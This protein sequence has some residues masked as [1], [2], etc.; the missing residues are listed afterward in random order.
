MALLLA[1]QHV[2][3]HVPLKEFQL[4]FIAEKAGLVDGEILEQL[5]QF[6]LALLADE[7]A[8]VAV[9]GIDAA[10]FEAANDRS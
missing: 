1:L 5:R 3:E 7:E 8:I 2:V 4:R 9:E 10:L 6:L